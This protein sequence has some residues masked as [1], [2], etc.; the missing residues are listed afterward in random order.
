MSPH[1]ANNA[2]HYI[3]DVCRDLFIALGCS[4]KAFKLG[5]THVFFR[6]KYEHFVEKYFGLDTDGTKKIS[7]IISGKF[8]IRQRHAMWALFNF[9]GKSKIPFSFKAISYAICFSFS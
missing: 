1:I 4:S 6:P 2:K 9:I 8:N 7:G 5:Q 3:R